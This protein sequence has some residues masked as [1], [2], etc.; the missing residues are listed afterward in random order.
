MVGVGSGKGMKAREARPQAE[1]AKADKV[2]CREVGFAHEACNGLPLV[3][4]VRR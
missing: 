1:P 4:F 3:I 2:L